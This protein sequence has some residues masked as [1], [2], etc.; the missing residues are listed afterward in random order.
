MRRSVP[1]RTGASAC[2]RR[3]ESELA[4]AQGRV[5]DRLE[6]KLGEALGKLDARA[7]ALRKFY[8][9]CD[10]RLAVM[11]RSNR[12][13]EE[14]QRLKELSGR[15]DIVIAEAQGTMEAI[16]R[17]FVAEARAIGDALGIVATVGIK[18]LAGVAPVENIE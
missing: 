3:P 12:D 11:D 10:A 8:N 17:A 5:A 15:A 4:G 2:A 1:S 7:V 9:D 18:S 16:A 14:S 13:L 6:A